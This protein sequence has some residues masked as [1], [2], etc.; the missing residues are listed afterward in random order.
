MQFLKSKCQKQWL[1]LTE[2]FINYN[3]NF[4]T[5]LSLWHWRSHEFCLQIIIFWPSP[6][7]IHTHTQNRSLRVCTE[8][9]KT[10][11]RY[12]PK[13]L[14][15]MTHKN[16]YIQNLYAQV[17]VK[18]ISKVWE[19]YSFMVSRIKVYETEEVLISSPISIVKEV[20]F[21]CMS[22]NVKWIYLYNLNK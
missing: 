21:T 10:S 14:N 15:F 6:I 8:F 22:V 7:Y 18:F 9:A 5:N 13:E 4:I 20:F 16:K 3:I 17:N 1:A 19:M 11:W 12:H 2:S